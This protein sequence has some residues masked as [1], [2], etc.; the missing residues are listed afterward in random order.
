MKDIAAG[1]FLTSEDEIDSRDVRRH[2][3]YLLDKIEGKADSLVSIRESGGSADIM[4]FWVSA[5]GQGGPSLWPT[6]M[7]KLAELDLEIWFDIYARE[8][9]D[10]RLDDG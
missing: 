6:Q 2:I 7:A 5:A 3:D 9:P 4:C 8:S 10:A 1:W